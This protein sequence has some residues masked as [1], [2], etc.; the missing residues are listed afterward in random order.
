MALQI[1]YT[2]TKFDITVPTAY[3]KIEQFS[4]NAQTVNF[5]VYIFA[6]QEARLSNKQIIGSFDFNIP[7]SDGM[8][9][10]AIYTYM[11]TLTK[12]SSAIDV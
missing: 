5:V 8:S 9:I 11:K 6:S 4:G 1:S 2:S 7:Y 3:A 10:S 12:F